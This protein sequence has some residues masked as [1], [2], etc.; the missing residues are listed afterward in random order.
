MTFSYQ[1]IFEKS[2][3]NTNYRLI[4]KDGIKVEKVSGR[5][6]LSVS[7]ETISKL[8]DVAFDDVSH[9]LR[10]SHLEKLSRILKDPEAS[11]N[12]IPIHGNNWYSYTKLLA[13]AYIELKSKNYLKKVLPNMITQQ[14]VFLDLI[15]VQTTSEMQMQKQ[16]S[17]S[18]RH[19]NQRKGEVC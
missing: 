15:N 12:D 9:L 6:I 4:S 17:C 11:E 2:E 1:P 7:P 10:T 5:E 14:I 13:D 16:S 3:D 8:A 18:P 19:F